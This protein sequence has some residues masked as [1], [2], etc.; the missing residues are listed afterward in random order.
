MAD[1]PLEHL[2]RPPAE[3]TGD[4]APAVVVLHGLGADEGD[5]LGAVDVPDVCHLLSVRA[6][7]PHGPGFSWFEFEGPDPADATP[8]A[9]DVRRSREVFDA[10]VADAVERYGLDAGRVGLFGF[11]QGAVLGLASLVERPDRYA[12]CV[13]SH[14]FYP[15]A[16]DPADPVDR[17]V[18]V[19]AGEHDAVVP[20]ERGADAADRLRSVGCDV[21]ERTYP[22]GHV[23]GQAERDDATDWVADRV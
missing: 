12:W 18:L 21:T 14:G 4:P 23:L 10:F 9:A 16:C 1:L 3:H 2:S 19:T 13:A 11:S 20:P 7:D 5:L 22:T 8:V 15:D 17:P 6:P